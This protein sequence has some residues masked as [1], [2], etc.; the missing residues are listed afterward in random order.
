MA[1]ME[2]KNGV[3]CTACMKLVETEISLSGPLGKGKRMSGAL[4]LDHTEGAIRVEF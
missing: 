1:V 2:G 3:A 4:C